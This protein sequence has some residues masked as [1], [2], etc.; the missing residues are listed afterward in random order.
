MDHHDRLS[1]PVAP[2][3]HRARSPR[4]AL[5]NDYTVAGIIIAIIAVVYYLSTLI[6]QVPAG[7]AQ[8]I[9]PASFPQGVLVSILVLL[10]LALYETREQAMEVPEPVPGLAYMTMAAMVISLVL[11]TQVD[12]FLGLIA[13]VVV[14]VPLWGMPRLGI[15]LLY[16]LCLHAV[17]FLLFSTFLRV[18]FPAGPLTSLFS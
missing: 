9:Q 15:A 16:A 10:L 4:S 2:A 5:Y 8:G 3:P 13:F 14:C 7:L 1:V 18:R 11:V 6:E 17:L 12:F